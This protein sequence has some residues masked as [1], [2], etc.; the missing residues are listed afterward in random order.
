MHTLFNMSFE[1]MYTSQVNKIK[2]TWHDGTLVYNCST[3]RTAIYHEDGSELSS[4]FTKAADLPLTVGSEIRVGKYLV[5]VESVREDA[6]ETI[7]NFVPHGRTT[8]ITPAQ[9]ETRPISGVHSV[10]RGANSGILGKIRR[11]PGLTAPIPPKKPRVGA[12]AF[13]VRLKQYG[14][15]ERQTDT[16]PSGGKS[17]FTESVGEIK[18]RSVGS[19]LSLLQ[20][21]PSSS[22]ANEM[23]SEV[24]DTEPGGIDLS[25][26][27]A[28]NNRLGIPDIPTISTPI[29]AQRQT[30]ANPLRRTQLS[31]DAHRNIRTDTYININSRSYVS[32]HDNA[33]TNKSTAVRAHRAF[34]PPQRTEMVEKS[35]LESVK[36]RNMGLNRGIQNYGDSSLGR[37]IGLDEKIE[38]EKV[39]CTETIVNSHIIPHSTAKKAFKPLLSS[40][41]GGKKQLYFPSKSETE[42]ST[43]SLQR[44]LCVPTRFENVMHY[45]LLFE[46]MLYEHMSIIIHKIAANYYKALSQM[47]L[48]LYDS[49]FT[50]SAQQHNLNA[51]CCQ[52]GLAQCSVVKKEGKNHGRMF[53][54]C[55]K[56]KHINCD[57]FKWADVEFNGDTGN[58][59]D[60]SVGKKKLQRPTNAKSVEDIFRSYSAMAFIGCNLSRANENSKRRY[61]K[62]R[63]TEKMTGG[64]VALTISRKEKSSFFAINDLW[65]LSPSVRF[66]EKTVLAR[67]TFYG[68]NSDGAIEL[69]P[70]EQRGV[71]SLLDSTVYALHLGNFGNEWSC[72]DVLREPRFTTAHM[73][74]LPY[75]VNGEGVNATTKAY[76][77]PITNCLNINIEERFDTVE[78]HILKY[79]LNSDQAM[80]LRKCAD[81][82]STDDTVSQTPPVVLVNGAFGSGKSYWMAVL[83]LLLVKLFEM[84]DDR[85]A[86][87]SEHFHTPSVT[88]QTDIK[89]ASRR[90]WKIMISSNTNVAV[91]R[92]LSLLL[93]FGYSEFVRVGSVKKIAKLILPH[94]VQSSGSKAQ[95]MKDLK[96]LL[97]QDNL[98]KQDELNIKESIQTLKTDTDAERLMEARVVGVTCAATSFPC[99]QAFQFPVVLLDESSQMMEPQAWL[100]I[101]PFAVEKLVLVGDHRQLP[102]TIQTECA[103]NCEGLGFTMFERLTRCHTQEVVPLYTQYRCHPSISRLSNRLFYKGELSDGISETDRQ[104]LAKK[105]PTLCFYDVPNGVCKQL[106]ASGSLFNAN[107]ATHVANIVHTIVAAGISPDEVGVITMYRA[108][109]E[110]IHQLLTP[111]AQKTFVSTVDAFQGGEREVVILSCVMTDDR[112]GFADS[113]RRINVAITRARRHLLIV[114]NVRALSKNNL[115]NEIIQSCNVEQASN[116]SDIGTL[117]TLNED[118]TLYDHKELKINFHKTDMHFSQNLNPRTENDISQHKGDNDSDVS[119]TANTIEYS[120]ENEQF[121]Y[122]NINMEPLHST[123]EEANYVHAYQESPSQFSLVYTTADP[124]SGIEQSEN[125]DPNVNDIYGYEEYTKVIRPSA[126][127]KE[128]IALFSNYAKNK[129]FDCINAHEY[130]SETDSTANTPARSICIRNNWDTN[131]GSR[132]ASA[133]YTNSNNKLNVDLKSPDPTLTVREMSDDSKFEVE[134]YHNIC[135]N[136]AGSS[137]SYAS[138]SSKQKFRRRGVKKLPENLLDIS[139]DRSSSDEDLLSLDDVLAGCRAHPQVPTVPT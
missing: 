24:P 84:N 121:G 75:I 113:Y 14:P 18:K 132:Y 102:P 36:L 134:K 85:E 56:P 115:W 9:T 26:L 92:V 110:R 58:G 13:Q 68:P 109:A 21:V 35:S 44:E 23:I 73:P 91:D 80:A 130:D 103:P 74:I 81:M 88:C 62:G 125:M 17:V 112:S 114:G 100:P 119:M 131:F 104:P 72:I 83:V 79:T 96:A 122:N 98:T 60:S 123:A 46:N 82:F 33:G 42:I 66:G 51:P 12:A 63:S 3:K 139:S 138:V 87:H 40:G 45:K 118:A 70:L 2:K 1:I 89:G 54:H 55:A 53:W 41:K 28:I 133:S 127:E 108:Q 117:C 78:D 43:A 5:T 97:K 8:F 94:R 137:G 126:M 29:Y 128:N 111:D 32:P 99:L 86:Q 49:D 47:D 59:S 11:A 27:P 19:I 124:S 76:T 52:H 90:P 57:F 4:D 38:P 135:S 71:Y 30:Y 107:E 116:F 95:D 6:K 105:L 65:A 77:Q 50:N 34:V 48:S 61:N 64:L 69:Q 39:Q 101:V 7:E 16:L 136:V 93:Q 129:D 67:S 25:P 31:S 120:N 10:S 106:S 15:R 20:K 22:N 37:A